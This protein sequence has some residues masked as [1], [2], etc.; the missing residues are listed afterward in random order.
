VLRRRDPRL[1]SVQSS[2]AA[3]AGAPATRRVIMASKPKA[4][5]AARTIATANPS[6]IW[7]HHCLATD[8]IV[9]PLD[10]GPREFFMS[11]DKST[12]NK[13]MAARLEAE[14]DVHKTLANAHSQ[15]ASALKS[16]G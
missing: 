15:V 11:L 7:G 9:G 2:T 8:P 1:I 12:Q 3:I 4:V 13:V 14:A 10:G 16:G 5:K 6:L